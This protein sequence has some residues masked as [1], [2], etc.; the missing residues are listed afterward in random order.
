MKLR[1]SPLERLAP[2]SARYLLMTN[3]IDAVR[4][5]REVS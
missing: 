3:H 1:T 5:L 4:R 2:R